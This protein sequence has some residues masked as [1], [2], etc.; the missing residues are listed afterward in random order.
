MKFHYV[1][2]MY[3]LPMQHA[4]SLVKQ[5]H[6]RSEALQI[7]IDKFAYYGKHNTKRLKE[8]DRNAF[9]KSFNKFLDT[10]NAILVRKSPR[11]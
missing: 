7:T 9:T 11:H 2:P 10:P 6:S 3:Y 1:A 5:G 4:I 8:F